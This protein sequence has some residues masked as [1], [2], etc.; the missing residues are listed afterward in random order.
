MLWCDNISA[1]YLSSNLVFHAHTKHVEIDFHFVLDI[2]G[3]GSLVVCF[4]SSKDQLANIFTKLLSSSQ[5][6]ML[7]TNLNVLP[8]RLS[9]WG[10]VKDK[11]CLPK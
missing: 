2:V 6:A 3:D 9:L 1:T 10:S 5:F 7:R 4:L 11:I 8:A